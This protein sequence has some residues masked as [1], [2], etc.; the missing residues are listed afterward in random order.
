MVIHVYEEISVPNKKLPELN[1]DMW[2]E[3]NDVVGSTVRYSALRPQTLKKRR[4]NVRKD[5]RIAF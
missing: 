1:D 3:R 5:S 2:C 4:R